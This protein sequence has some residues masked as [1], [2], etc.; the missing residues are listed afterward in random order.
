MDY[1]FI[2]F[3]PPQVAEVLKVELS[4]VGLNINYC[5][6]HHGPQEQATQDQ[7]AELLGGPGLRA[8]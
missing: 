8:R 6:C 7:G 3:C 1:V 5:G 2:R 4:K